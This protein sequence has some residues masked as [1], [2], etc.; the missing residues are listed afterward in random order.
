MNRKILKAALAGTAVLALAAG[1]GTWSSWSDWSTVTGSQVGADQLKLVVNESTSSHFNDMKLA[2]GLRIDTSYVVANRTGTTIPVADLTLQL[3]NLVGHEDG[4]TSTSSEI[5]V[6]PDCNDT[7]TPGEFIDEALINVNVTA[8]TTNSD[9]CTL[10]HGSIPGWPQM[11]L[12]AFRD[13]TATTPVPVGSLG[14]GQ[15]V[16]VALAATMPTTASNASQGDSASFDM[17]F[18]LNQHVS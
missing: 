12:R 16:C 11:S 4:C 10:N 6:D 3:T 1:G 14:P 2:P 18:M 13:L 8:P 15:Y 7:A 17:K 5:A 9:P